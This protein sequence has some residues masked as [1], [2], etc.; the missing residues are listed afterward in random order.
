[1]AEENK[2]EEFPPIKVKVEGETIEIDGRFKK[3]SE[4]VANLVEISPDEEI[5]LD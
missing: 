4:L 1:M 3:L 2:D 5:P